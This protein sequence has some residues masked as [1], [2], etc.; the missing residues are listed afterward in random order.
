MFVYK[1]LFFKYVFTDTL[2]NVSKCLYFMLLFRQ[3]GSYV[4][5]LSI[6][7][8]RY[9]DL[10]YLSAAYR[11]AYAYQCYVVPQVFPSVCID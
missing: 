4:R 11:Y 3:V 7:T 9:I 6:N 1:L 2:T 10:Q 8:F 5:L